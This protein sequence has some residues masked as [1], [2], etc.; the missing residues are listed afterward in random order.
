MN[1]QFKK[2]EKY[3]QTSWK[4]SIPEIKKVWT[5]KITGEGPA[6]FNHQLRQMNLVGPSTATW[7][8][9][10]G[11]YRGQKYKGSVTELKR[12]TLFEPTQA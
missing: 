7:S 8:T 9:E 12:A 2:L 6:E 11:V 10:V 4:L 5:K 3:S 1:D